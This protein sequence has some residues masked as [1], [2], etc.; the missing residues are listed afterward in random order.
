[1]TVFLLIS[2][3][4]F[5]FGNLIPQSGD[6]RY[7]FS[8][9]VTVLI[10]LIPVLTMRLFSEER[11]LKTGQL[12]LSSPVSLTE[13]VLGK[14]FAAMTLLLAALGATLLYPAVLLL[15]GA[16]DP[17][18]TAGNYAGII[19]VAAAFV[20]LGMFIS[21]LT[22]N[23]LVAAVLSYCLLLGLWLTGFLSGAV[24]NALL[25]LFIRQLSLLERYGEFTLGVI[26]PASLLY[27]ISVSAFFIIMTVRVLGHRQWS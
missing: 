13:I 6:L 9:V 18:I 22:D 10:F 4:N 27:Y 1:M 16:F 15:F 11:K 12:L 17:G 19:L 26:N 24:H 7:F 3:F 21:A 5:T 2:G 25:S 14:F 8:R 23:Q 20:S